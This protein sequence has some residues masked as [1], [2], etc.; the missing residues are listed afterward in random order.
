[1]VGYYSEQ[2]DH[3]TDDRES[4][5]PVTFHWYANLPDMDMRSDFHLDRYFC[6]VK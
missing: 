3:R 6:R 1:L 5:K 4:D 2:G